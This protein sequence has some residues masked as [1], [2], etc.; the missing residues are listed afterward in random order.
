MRDLIPFKQIAE[1]VCGHMGLP[2]KKLAVIHAKTVI[3][4][5]ASGA[6]TLARLEPGRS[7]PTSKFFKR[8]VPMVS[9]TTKPEED[10]GC[11]GSN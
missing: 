4:D 11:K 5:D 1:E 10:R 7:T 9:R 6:L 2:N 8:E 3:H